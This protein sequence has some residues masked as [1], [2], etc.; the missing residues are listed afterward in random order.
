M[1]K[2]LSIGGFFGRNIQVF[3][4]FVTFITSIFKCLRRRYARRRVPFWFGTHIQIPSF[5]LNL[6]ICYCFFLKKGPP[7]APILIWHPFLKLPTSLQNYIKVLLDRY[8]QPTSNGHIMLNAPMQPDVLTC[9][10][11]DVLPDEWV[12]LPRQLIFARQLCP[13]Q[14]VLGITLRLT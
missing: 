7:Q 2:C 5:S 10:W 8:S 9:A 1:E 13:Q 12:F 14:K 4:T 6:V 11:L 3:I